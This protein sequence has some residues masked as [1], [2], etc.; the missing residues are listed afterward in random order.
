MARCD[1]GSARTA[2]VACSAFYRLQAQVADQVHRFLDALRVLEEDRAKG[3]A[4]SHKDKSTATRL[5]KYMGEGT[6]REHRKVSLV[7]AVLANAERELRS[8]AGLTTFD[9]SWGSGGQ[10]LL[11]TMVLGNELNVNTI[12]HEAIHYGTHPLRRVGNIP[13]IRDEASFP[14][15]WPPLGRSRHPLRGLELA[16]ISPPKS[17]PRS[18]GW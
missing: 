2:G 11:G 16:G 5:D 8:L 18:L 17:L 14:G 9:K 1:A 3:A 4:F 10:A 6:S 15:R 13:F 7:F 12:L